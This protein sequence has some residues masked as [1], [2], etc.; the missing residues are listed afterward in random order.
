MSLLMSVLE[1]PTLK[2]V[3]VKAVLCRARCP[4]PHRRRGHSR[5]RAPWA[6]PYA[7][8]VAQARR[9]FCG[10]TVLV[11]SPVGLYPDGTP[12][13]RYQ[14]GVVTA[15]SSDGSVRVRFEDGCE[16]H[17]GVSFALASFR[18]LSA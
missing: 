13:F 16:R 3:P 1:L 12:A 18:V 8:L 10:H 17:F 11:P 7:R 9:L 15:V 4:R 14:R 5:P 2:E 6:V